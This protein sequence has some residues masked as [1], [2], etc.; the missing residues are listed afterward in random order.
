MNRSVTICIVLFIFCNITSCNKDCPVDN[1]SGTPIDTRSYLKKTFDRYHETFDVYSDLDAA[2]NHFVLP[3]RMNNAP[4]MDLG[5]TNNP[6]SGYTCIKATYTRGNGT[7]WSGWYFLNGVLEG[8]QTSPSVNW[9]DIPDAGV[10]VGSP[11]VLTFYAKGET[12][13]ERVE[14]FLAGAGRDENGN[15]IEPYPDSSPKCSTGYITLTRDWKQYSINTTGRNLSYVLGGF[16]WVSRDSENNSSITFYLDDIKFNSTRLTEPRLLVSYEVENQG[17]E[18]DKIMKNVSFIYDDALALMAFLAEGNNAD[19]KL[20]AD[21]FVYITQHDRFYVT[22]HIRNGYM[23]GDLKTFPGWIPNGRQFTVRM[24]GWT[25]NNQWNEDEFCVSTHTGNAAWLMLGLLA[26]YEK[27]GS[28][29]A[30]YLNAAKLTGDWIHTNCFDTRG[31]GGYTAGFEGWEPAPAELLYKATEHNIDLYSAFQR[32]YLNTNDINW[33]YRADHAK[34]FVISMYDTVGG[35]FFT[36]T[37]NDGITINKTVIPLDIQAWA[38][39]SLKDEYQNFLR[40]LN[41]A[42]SNIKVGSGYSFSNFDLSTAWMEGTAQMAAAYAFL[43]SSNK[44]ND[45][46]NFIESSKDPSGAIYATQSGTLQTGFDWIYY[47]RKHV[48]A[49]AWYVLAKNKLNPFW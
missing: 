7:N 6:N 1:N 47:H 2:G 10:N 35:K 32:I 43:D 40:A 42:D 13:N 3:G 4:P 48:G 17:S 19:A 36:G 16:G 29:D 27:T 9:G 34:N 26:Y 8:N 18:F 33:K 15:P 28:S 30:A 37:A 41:F 23:G 46:M 24:P 38:V 5:F 31:A 11:G 45:I 44:Y 14:F 20:I 12:G 22:G 49:T 21:G 25:Q 39:L